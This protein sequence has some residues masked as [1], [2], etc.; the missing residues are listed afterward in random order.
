MVGRVVQAKDDAE[1][2]RDLAAPD[3]D[4]EA[5]AVVAAR[6]ID[7]EL[8]A[9]ANGAPRAMG[10]CDVV[11]YRDTRIALRCRADAPALLVV[12][13]TAMRGWRAW[14]DGAPAAIVRA[15]VAM[16]G[17]ALAPAPAPHDVELR[18][19]PPGFVEALLIGAL[20]WLTAALAV[21][22][23]SRANLRP[24]ARTPR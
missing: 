13:D 24:S 1:A 21:A 5:A 14:V 23:S 12:A 22:R 4:P 19:E 3:F 2:L 7:P 20:G 9:L 10:G 17:V 6:E 15:N 16:R 11:D 18:F 8:A